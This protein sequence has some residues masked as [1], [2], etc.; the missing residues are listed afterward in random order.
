MDRLLHVIHVSYSRPEYYAES[1]FT[2]HYRRPARRERFIW[3]VYRST[4][5]SPQEFITV[6]ELR[7]TEINLCRLTQTRGPR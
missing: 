3:C 6:S 7:A 4:F 1:K 2:T 5:F